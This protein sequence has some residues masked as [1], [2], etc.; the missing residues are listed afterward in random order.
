FTKGD[1]ISTGTSPIAISFPCTRKRATR[2]S[3]LNPYRPPTAF[4]RMGPRLS[5]HVLVYR[6]GELRRA[7]K[8]SQAAL[9]INRI[10][11]FL[12]SLYD[13]ATGSGKKAIPS[14][15][16]NSTAPSL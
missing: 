11:R 16:G 6:A 2:H 8:I 4:P 10:G 14:R 3:A 12:D 15:Q 1:S 5:N 9:W 7:E 13:F